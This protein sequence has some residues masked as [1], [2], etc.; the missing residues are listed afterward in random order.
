[1]PLVVELE[2]GR[3]V[4][5]LGF[6]VQVVRFGLL[7]CVAAVLTDVHLQRNNISSLLC[8]PAAAS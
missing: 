4:R 2:E 7:R 5:V 8:A 6:E 1:M 3:G